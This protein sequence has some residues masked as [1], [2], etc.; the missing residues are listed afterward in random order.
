MSGV[1]NVDRIDIGGETD[2]VSITGRYRNV[3]TRAHA[4]GLVTVAAYSGPY[5]ITRASD[6]F[7][8]DP[9]A[10]VQWA[11]TTAQNGVNRDPAMTATAADAVVV[12]GD[13]LVVWREANLTA[14]QIRAAIFDPDTTTWTWLDGGGA[15]G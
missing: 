4:P 9:S 13:H 6:G 10:W 7:V 3:T 2:S 1:Q 15:N 14:T 5:E 11:G 12:A 8:F